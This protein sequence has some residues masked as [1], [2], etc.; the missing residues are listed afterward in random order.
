MAR[1]ESKTSCSYMLPAVR[2]LLN[3]KAAM[4]QNSPFLPTISFYI[5]APDYALW[6][7]FTT[8]E[9]CIFQHLIRLFTRANGASVLHECERETCSICFGLEQK[10]NKSGSCHNLFSSSPPAARNSKL[11]LD[12]IGFLISPPQ[13][14]CF[15]FF[16]FCDLL[17]VQL[18]QFYRHL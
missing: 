9:I 2:A 4:H 12:V 14:N 7:G 5:Y 13:N 8:T 15:F 16:V 6:H 17:L 18:L 1:C 11:F 10:Q 3:S